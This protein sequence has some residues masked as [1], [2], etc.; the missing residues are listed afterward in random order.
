MTQGAAVSCFVRAFVLTG[1]ELFLKIAHEASKPLMIEIKHGGVAYVDKNGIWLEETPSPFS[2][3]HVLNGF[4]YAIEGLF[5]L[6]CISEDSKIFNILEE[7]ILTLKKNIKKYDSGYWSFYQLNPA[8]LA[9]L[10]YH[11]LHVQQLS[12]LYKV[13]E[14]DIFRE[15]AV[16]FNTYMRSQKNCLISRICGNMLYLNALFKMQGVRAFPYIT[17]RI[18]EITANKILD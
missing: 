13:T 9:P 4:I 8:L 2:P 15:Y 10:R 3:S 1:N 16:R 18:T 5:D 12:F 7:T 17:R 6:F 14:E 11:M